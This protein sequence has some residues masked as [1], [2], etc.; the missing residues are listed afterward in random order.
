[1]D[2]LYYCPSGLQAHLQHVVI[3]ILSGPKITSKELEIGKPPVNS[4]NMHSIK[5]PDSIRKP[6]EQKVS[7]SITVAGYRRVKQSPARDKL[8]AYWERSTYNAY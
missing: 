8:A 2:K 3:S 1:M 5:D 7:D 6:F 4:T